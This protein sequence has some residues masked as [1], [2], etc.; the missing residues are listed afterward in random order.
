VLVY[1][2]IGTGEEAQLLPFLHPVAWVGFPFAFLLHGDYA[3]LVGNLPLFMLAG[4][5]LES[6]GRVAASARRF[7]LW[8]LLP[9]LLPFFNSSTLPFVVTRMFSFGLSFS[10][11]TM[12]VF[13]VA[14][15]LF[16]Y[17]QRA[18]TRSTA[19]ALIAVGLSNTLLYGWAAAIAFQGS[20]LSAFNLQSGIGHVL[21]PLSSVVILLVVL[22]SKRSQD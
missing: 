10:I 16:E 21:A 22:R 15:A 11:E 4:T 6:W 7:A 9:L 20:L 17:P 1:C 8:Y 5:L 18:H 2:L 19:I 14:L 3:H 12:A 13:A